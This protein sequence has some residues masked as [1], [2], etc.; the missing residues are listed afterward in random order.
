MRVVVIYKRETDYERTVLSYLRDFSY[1]TGH[2][3][4]SIDPDSIEGSK[5]C[6]AY[7]I[8]EYPTIIALSS[9][10]AVQNMWR[11][12]PLPTINEVSYYA[13]QN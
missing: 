6:E 4:E 2:E 3:L 12:M 5:F 7:D 11:G 9:N 8:I 10:G 13:G 1:Q